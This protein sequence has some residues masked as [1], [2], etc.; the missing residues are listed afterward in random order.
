LKI[1]LY[2]APETLRAPKSDTPYVLEALREHFDVSVHTEPDVGRAKD[3]DVVFVRFKLPIRTRFLEELTRLEHSKLIVNRPTGQL[4]LHTK[5]HVLRFG[6]L[7]PPTIV[8]DAVEE[9]RA[10]AERHETVVLKPLDRHMGVGVLR[11]GRAQLRRSDFTER[12]AAYVAEYGVPVVQK[13][14]EE[15][16]T[17]GCRRVNVFGFEP[18]SVEAGVP[19]EGGFICLEALGATWRPAELTAAD[20]AVLDRVVPVL[21][22]HGIWWA[23]VDLMGP[24]LGE[25]NVVQPNTVLETDRLHGDRRG[26][27]AI[28]DRLERYR[29][30]RG[31]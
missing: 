23:G 25:L 17:V 13:Y 27:D 24:Y 2:A 8:T 9:V 4:A 29:I 31:L 28:V 6:D 10:F 21:E 7:A 30:A 26:V 20:R 1:A 16:E 3:A 11:L 19:G 15:V 5:R 18:I 14:V 12:L 22:A